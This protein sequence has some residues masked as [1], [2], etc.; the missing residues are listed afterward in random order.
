MLEFA[1]NTLTR[2]C[3]QHC[4]ELIQKLQLDLLEQQEN[5]AV[6]LKVDVERE[7]FI[8]RLQGCWTQLVDHWK[9]LENQRQE[10]ATMLEQERAETR[11]LAAT[12][13]QVSE[14]SF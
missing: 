4:E 7:E 9:E 6:A 10:L 8:K 2:V 1:G 14:I 11:K 3:F 13:T 12:S 5:L